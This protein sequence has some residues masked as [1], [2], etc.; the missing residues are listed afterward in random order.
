[1]GFFDNLFGEP[2]PAP[3]PKKK[4]AATLAA[5]APVVTA[6]EGINP[7]IVAVIMASVYA[8][9]GTKKVSVMIRHADK[10]WAAAGRQKLMDVR[11]FV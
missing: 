8:M 9:T 10:A 7:E 2:K 4:K 6:V 3:K 1:M 11:Q 5:P